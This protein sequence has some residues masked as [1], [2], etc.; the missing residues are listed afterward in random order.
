MTSIVVTGQVEPVRPRAVRSYYMR[1]GEGDLA[2]LKV[3]TDAFPVPSWVKSGGGTIA[4]RRADLGDDDIEK[5][6]RDWIWR[7]VNFTG[8]D[9]GGTPPTTLRALDIYNWI[10]NNAALNSGKGPTI[11]CGTVAALYCGF[12]APYGIPSRR[13]WG[14]KGSTAS[15]D[16]ANE[17]WSPEAGGWVRVAAYCNARDIWAATG[18]GAS[19]LD[20]VTVGRQEGDRH[21]I[22]DTIYEGG[23]T[24]AGY[25]SG[26][27]ND[28][29]G[30]TDYALWGRGDRMQFTGGIAGDPRTGRDGNQAPNLIEYLAPNGAS[31][32]SQVAAMRPFVV[33]ARDL[34]DIVY[35]PTAMT[36]RA[37]LRAGLVV[38]QLD[39]T[40]FE[41]PAKYQVKPPAGAWTDL[42]GPAD[43][44]YAK[45]G[46][47]QYRAVGQLG[48]TT[49]TVTI[50]VV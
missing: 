3:I 44:F 40:M 14:H 23:S 9:S 38:V 16:F 50:T 18:K 43:S 13:M 8:T 48:N 2:A 46:A 47:W 11:S 17:Y 45:P 19:F 42:R 5:C 34:T 12:L 21:G 49:Q 33:V 37:Q 20:E 26:V 31:V 22:V 7:A 28:L 6:I 41:T 24:N 35:T 10:Q 1:S 29:Y 36:A 15:V 4:S 39:V 30:F 25:R 32:A 27:P